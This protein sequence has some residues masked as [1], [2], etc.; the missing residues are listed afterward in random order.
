[1]GT[2]GEGEGGPTHVNWGANKREQGGG[3]GQRTRSSAGAGGTIR[4]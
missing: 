3:S 1:M 2:G 4:E